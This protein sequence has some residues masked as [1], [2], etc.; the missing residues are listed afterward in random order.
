VDFLGAL[1]SVLGNRKTGE[2]DTL[3]TRH[4]LTEAR[5]NLRVLLAE[6]NVV[7]QEVAA[8]MLRRRGHQV[9]VVGDGVEAVAAVQ[10]AA[11]D[12]VLMDVQMPEMDGFEATAAIRKIPEGVGLPI[13]AL[14]AHALAGERERCLEHGLDGYLSKPVKAQELFAAVEGWGGQRAA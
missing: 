1:A 5:R 6:D 8:T 14:T 2:S 9:D 4:T 3:V 11:Y 13:I 7:N 12:V 10:R